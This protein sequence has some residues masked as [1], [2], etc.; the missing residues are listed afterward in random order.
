MRKDGYYSSGEF[1]K[2]ANVTKKTLRYY[3]EKNIL[4]P[5][6]VLGSGARLYSDEDM[7]R[8]Q[9]VLLFKYLGFSLNEIREMMV[10]ADN[11]HIAKSLEIQ[12]KLVE[13][14]IEQLHLVSQSIRNTAK[15]LKNNQE[16]DWSQML[17]IINI[18]RMEASLKNQYKNAS[19]ISAR[20]QL[21]TLFS[22][23]RQLWFPWIFEQLCLKEGMHVLEVGC[24]DGTLWNNRHLPDH[25]TVT[26]TDISEGMI[27]DVKRH[28]G[29]YNSKFEFYVCDC[30]VLPFADSSFDLV[31]ANHV[32]FYCSDIV[33]ACREIYRVLKKGGIVVCGT[34]GKQHMKEI[35][36][37]VT[38]FDNRIVLSA[39]RL[40][41][42][43]GKENGKD[44]LGQMF[45]E[46]EW[47][48]YEDSL[49]VTDSEAL[50]AYILSCHGNQNQY[51]IDCYDEF[52]GFVKRKSKNGFYVTKEAG[53]FF[54][55]K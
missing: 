48:S 46:V 18:T 23:N 17:D 11:L 21:H 44:I 55:K 51:I 31:I 41:D 37:L 25:T 28:L 14:R 19:N 10:D 34:Y 7:G 49:K 5:S 38:E 22:Q 52:K 3:D 47:R 4:K 20:I 40:Y 35:S 12:N 45:C 32:L 1:A 30:Q 39:D 8:L 53:I 33:K 36:E 16:A 24:G 9:Q 15:R 2:K 50:I 27:R 42:R 29:V 13:D 43:F 26:L 54:A 6:C